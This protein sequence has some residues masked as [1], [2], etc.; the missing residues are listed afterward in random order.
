MSIIENFSALSEKELYDFAEALVKTI[1]SEHI[2]TSDANFSVYSVEADELSGDLEIVIDHDDYIKIDRKA[3]WTCRDDEDLDNE[4]EDISYDELDIVDAKNAFKTLS[5]EIEGYTV[6]LDIADV[7]VEEIAAFD[8]DHYT[9]E[10][11]GI[12][13]YEYAGHRGYDSRPYLEVYGTVTAACNCAL[14]LYVS[15]SEPA[16]DAE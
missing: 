2:F 13:D 15:V 14:A 8:V 10:D 9:E 1:N 16:I 5:T 12:G 7:D 3:T 6:S 11:S 4:P